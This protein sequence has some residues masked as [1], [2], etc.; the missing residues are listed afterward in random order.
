MLQRA[1]EG[2]MS[3][4]MATRIVR[5]SGTTKNGNVK[6]I[7]AHVG[8]SGNE[9]ADELANKGTTDG[10]PMQ[11]K[12]Q[13]K[14]LYRQIDNDLL[15]NWNGWFLTTSTGKGRWYCD[16]NRHVGKVPW[17]NTG[18]MTNM[19]TRTI[20]RIIAGHAYTQEWLARMKVIDTGLCEQCNVQTDITTFST[21]ALDTEHQGQ[22]T[23]S[24]K[25]K[26]QSRPFTRKRIRNHGYKLYAS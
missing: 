11:Y 24:W 19:N 21:S 6:W 14:D 5:K 10:T 15:E 17:Y 1:L 3:N 23:I 9:K 13:L 12:L 2:D 25:D 16:I 22:N 18:D 26:Q 7:P 20:Y 4:Q 8:I